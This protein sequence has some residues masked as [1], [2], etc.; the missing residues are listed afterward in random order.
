[1]L[2][3]KTSFLLIPCYYSLTWASVTGWWKRLG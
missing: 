1:M 2:Q 3:L